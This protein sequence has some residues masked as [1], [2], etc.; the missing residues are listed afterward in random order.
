[1]GATIE[2]WNLQKCDVKA[3]LSY[4]ELKAEVL[5]R[6]CVKAE[7]LLRNDAEVEAPLSD[8]VEVEWVKV[9]LHLRLPFSCE[10]DIFLDD[11]YSKSWSWGLIC[12]CISLRCIVLQHVFSFANLRESLYT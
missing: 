9:C 1:M 12:F 3:P 4:D 6:D 11:R 5:L 10:V 2:K 8:H 7:A